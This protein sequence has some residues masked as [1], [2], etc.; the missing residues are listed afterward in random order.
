M[1]WNEHV[2]IYC[3]RGTDP[4]FWAEPFNALSNLAFI[5]AAAA[6]LRD[7]LRQPVATRY[8]EQYLLVAG[9]FA[10]G[11]G[12]FLFHTHANRWSE[13]ADV[14]PIGLVMLG[15]L[16][17]MLARFLRLPLVWRIA[18]IMAFVLATH[19]AMGLRCGGGECLNGSIGYVP[20]LLGLTLIGLMLRWR[21]HPASP[22]LLTAAGVFL[23]SLT[24][25]TFDRAWCDALGLP[26]HALGTHFLWHTLNGLMLYLLLT[27][28]I[29]HSRHGLLPAPGGTLAKA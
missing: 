10:I 27:A 20:A 14:V 23:A 21:G 25:R 4:A 17:V 13:L 12:S 22:R 1:Q 7:L 3:E 18:G 8:L 26:G 24:L 6:G 19:I 15:M 11:I 28:A 16:A 29:R 9:I 5:L 2:F